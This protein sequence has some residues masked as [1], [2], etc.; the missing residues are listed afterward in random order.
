MLAKPVTSQMA[1]I[2]HRHFPARF[3]IKQMRYGATIGIGGNIGDVVR[4]FEKLLLILKR[5]P[6]IELIASGSILKNPPFGFTE[7]DDFYNS[8]ISIAT[9]MKARALLQHLL[10]IEARLG[11]KRSFK[12]APRTMDIDLIFFENETKMSKDLIL[13]HPHWQ[14]RASVILPLFDMGVQV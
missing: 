1:S 11:R 2:K 12:N 6:K 10:R 3:A 14:K 7:Q 4:R 5:D 9:N 8:V 13:P